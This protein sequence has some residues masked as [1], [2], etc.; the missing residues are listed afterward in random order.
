M[1]WATSCF[2]SDS[3][4]RLNAQSPSQRWNGDCV[5]SNAEPVTPKMRLFRARQS[6]WGIRQPPDRYRGSHPAYV[7]ALHGWQL[8]VRPA[9]SPPLIT[10]HQ[11]LITSHLTQS[12]PA[13]PV[14][15]SNQD[16]GRRLG[17]SDA[18]TKTGRE[19]QFT[20]LRVILPSRYSL[21]TSRLGFDPSTSRS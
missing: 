11:S 5:F 9:T 8:S 13:R 15:R 18:T 7:G 1:C 4:A 16:R 10:S 12:W 14:I 17:I 19:T 2:R 6:A 3:S 21:K 20:S